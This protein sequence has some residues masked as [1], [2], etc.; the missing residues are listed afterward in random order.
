[1]TR[2]AATRATEAADA[3]LAWLDSQPTQSFQRPPEAP[4]TVA[5]PAAADA[6]TVQPQRRGEVNA[7]KS[8]HPAH[9]DW[10]HHRLVV[11]GPSVDVDMFRSAAS[12]AGTIPWHLDLDPQQRTLS[13]D[14]ARVLAGQ[15]RAAVSRRHALAVAR[16]GQSQVC[17]LDLHALVPVP[18]AMLR[19]GPDD[20]ESRDWLWA[21]WGTT[22]A[23]R[24]VVAPSRQAGQLQDF[25]PNGIAANGDYT[26]FH[27]TFWSADWTP[28]RAFA[29]I[30]A[31]WPALRFDVRPTYGVL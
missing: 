20:P 19:L 25:E 26:A 11:S 28:W 16:V 4:P 24:H 10:L 22:Q 6:P 7:G 1:V 30:A 15:L 3:L 8:R 17:P 12:G 27:L 13:V 31:R 9:T 18:P 23:L 5:A 21:Q 29:H 2:S 14:G